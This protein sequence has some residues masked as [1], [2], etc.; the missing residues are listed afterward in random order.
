MFSKSPTIMRSKNHPCLKKKEWNY[1]PNWTANWMIISPGWKGSPTRRDGQRID[2]RKY[3]FV[4]KIA[5][6]DAHLN[7]YL[8]FLGNGK[9]SFLYDF[10]P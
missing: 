3:A 10:G 1:A 6:I 5:F 8:I 4:L 2:G 9:A 7:M